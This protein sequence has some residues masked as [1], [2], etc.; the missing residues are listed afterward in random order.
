MHK[1]CA[2]VTRFEKVKGI[3]ML[4]QRSVTQ[5]DFFL[6]NFL[7][8]WLPCLFHTHLTIVWVSKSLSKGH[9]YK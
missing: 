7:I 3:W 8:C 5:L 6:L 1:I 9:L 2:F 4:L